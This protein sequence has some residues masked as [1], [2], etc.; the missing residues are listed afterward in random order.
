MRCQRRETVDP[1]NPEKVL[2]VITADRSTF[3][4]SDLEKLLGRAM[5]SRVERRE[6]TDALLARPEIIGLRETAD[7]PVTRYTTRTVLAAEREVLQ[8]AAALHR[9]MAYGMT[10]QIKQETL[11]CYSH[12]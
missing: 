10:D 8:D 2:E 12:M 3:T 5:V 7:A 4:R 6:L 11:D 9:K 1:H